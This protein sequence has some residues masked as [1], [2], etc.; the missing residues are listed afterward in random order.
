MCE[1]PHGGG[2]GKYAC[3]ECRCRCAACRA[4]NTD[5][6]R[7]WRRRKAYG[8]AS[9]VDA[10]PVRAHVRQLQ[11]A[12]LGWIR[13]AELAG[14]S[15]SVI[16]ELLYGT[17]HREPTKRVR[18]TTARQILAVT[19]T[20]GVLADAAHIDATG[21][22]RRLQALVA[23]GWS[24]SELARRLGVLPSNFPYLLDRDQVRAATARAVVALYDQLWNAPPPD[25]NARWRARR[26]AEAKGWLPPLAWDDETIDDPA[27]G[28]QLGEGAGPVVDEVAIER[29]LAGQAK[30][31]S[32]TEAEKVAVAARVRARGDGPTA[33]SKL[34]RCSGARAHQLLAAANVPAEATQASA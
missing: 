25:E 23:I 22:R 3:S 26:L 20:L 9:F 34:L 11:A 1:R 8:V 2:R 29:V 15:R 16:A 32:L 21:T 13:I 5:A 19:A 10:V 33:L 28:P 24:Q 17:A 30:P 4:A 6:M 12:G 18:P 7:E 14:V 31:G 27:A